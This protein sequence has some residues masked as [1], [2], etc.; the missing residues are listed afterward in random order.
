M[1]KPLC[2]F[3]PRVRVRVPEIGLIAQITEIGAASEREGGG[4]QCA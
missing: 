4:V 1:L 2:F 3:L